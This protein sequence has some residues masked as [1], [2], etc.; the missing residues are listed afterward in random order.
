MPLLK[1]FYVVFPYIKEL[2]LGKETARFKRIKT[3][4]PKRQLKIAVIAIGVASVLLNTKLVQ[5][6]YTDRKLHNAAERNV[7]TKPVATEPIPTQ[8]LPEVVSAAPAMPTKQKRLNHRHLGTQ[9]QDVD[10]KKTYDQL[11]RINLEV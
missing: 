3:K 6:I 10:D 7:V 9:H 5:I 8:T 2:F 11:E 4:D 1:I